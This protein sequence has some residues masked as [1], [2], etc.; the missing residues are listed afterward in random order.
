MSLRLPLP[1]ASRTRGRVQEL[2]PSSCVV[3][4]LFVDEIEKSS[5]NPPIETTLREIRVNIPSI[6]HCHTRLKNVG[7]KLHHQHGSNA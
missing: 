7:N 4:H 1:D 6:G 3:K 2:A 5:F